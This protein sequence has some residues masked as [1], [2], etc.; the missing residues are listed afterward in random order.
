MSS[1]APV[2]SGSVTQ[3]VTQE[4]VSVEFSANPVS[5]GSGKGAELLAGTQSVV[6]FRIADANGG[7]ALT[8]LRPAVWID[9]HDPGQASDSR[10]CRE[11]I[12][13]FLQPSFDR[14]PTVDLNA[15]FI[16]ALNGEPNISVIDPY[17]GFGGSKLFT[18]IPLASSGADWVISRD[19]K[20]LFVSMPG[21]RQVAIID[22]VNWK[23]STN[24]HTGINPSRLALQHDDRYLWVA[25]DDT[26]STASGVTVV[27]TISLNVVATLVTGEGSHE[28]A[29]DDEDNRAVVTN[30]QAGTISVIDVRTL[31]K[32]TSSRVGSL[33]SAIAF[34]GLSK[35][36]YVANEGDGT[37]VELDG[38]GREKR[39][40]TA[41]SGLG[42]LKLTSDG[43][44]G[45]VVNRLRNNVAIFD[46]ASGKIIHIVPVGPAPDQ[47]T[48]T[49]D[50]AYVR[51]SGNEFVTMIKIAE[52]GKEAAL[53][54]F[55]AGQKA[56]QESRS[57]SIAAAIVPSRG[58]G[59]VLVANPADKMIYFYAE[60]MAAPM[61]SFQNYRREPRAL[62]IVDQSLRE[63]NPGEYTTTVNL[64]EAGQYDVAFLLD[65]PRLVNCFQLEVAEN[66]SLTKPAG[67]AM[68]I[69]PV[70]KD[71]IAA[72]D[73]TH[74]LR[75]RVI[76]SHSNKPIT[77]LNEV[78]VLVFLAPGIWQQR[79][80]AK[81]LGEG[82]YETSFVPP[83]AGV[84]YVFFRSPSL[85]T[86]FNQ[87]QPLILQAVKK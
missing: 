24:I 30:K 34:S 74:N 86:E 8:N 17:G 38:S 62:L 81:D 15:Y 44:F 69:D 64:S 61:G 3:R 78:E 26:S 46:V 10:R 48:F 84:Y 73:K 49:R 7:K 19:R 25:D 56:P 39:R 87:V 35:S 20:K 52:L 14:R 45:F 51:S 83:K 85:K 59:A 22:T 6:R 72:V 57:R 37:I 67:V 60:G 1:P 31:A 23:V 18:L 71:E 77:N 63:G 70:A 53:S 13:S 43:R 66:P 16:L 79:A 4:G 21:A 41:E 42:A 2:N 5:T 29:L 9:V 11:K 27:D 55:P 36:F 40:M 28:I 80:W 82:L 75:F 12:Q 32:V 54:R 68:G 65:S 47:V 50:F 33:P 76:D 58:D